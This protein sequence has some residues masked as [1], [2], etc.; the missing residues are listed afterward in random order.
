VVDEVPGDEGELREVAEDRLGIGGGRPMQ[1][2]P[3]S[4]GANGPGFDSE[5]PH[6]DGLARKWI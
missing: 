5:I 4:R 3:H 6:V 2:Q 1:R